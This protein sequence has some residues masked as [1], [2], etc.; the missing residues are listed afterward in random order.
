MDFK[1]G[2]WVESDMGVGIYVEEELLSGGQA[3]T[4][5][6]VH[7][8]NDDGTTKLVVDAAGLKDLRKARAS[9]IPAC[10][11]EHLDKSQ[12]TALGYE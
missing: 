5:G 10:R 2:T 4:V 11:V 8:T 9:A 3:R 1:N 7:L 12:L 6:Q